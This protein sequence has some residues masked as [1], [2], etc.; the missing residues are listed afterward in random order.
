[1]EMSGKNLVAR[2]VDRVAQESSGTRDT[3]DHPAVS[4]QQRMTCLKRFMVAGLRARGV[5][6][7]GMSEGFLL[8]CS[9]LPSHCQRGIVNTTAAG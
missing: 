7:S 2:T 3:G 8:L 4:P 1:M 5:E 9:W 6:Y